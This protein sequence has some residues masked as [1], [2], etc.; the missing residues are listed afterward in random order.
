MIFPAA[1]CLAA[2]VAADA[3]TVQVAIVRQAASATLM[4]DGETLIAQP[5]AK[6]MPLEWKGELALRPRD[7]GLRLANLRLKTETRLL[8]G[9]G[10]RIRVGPN[11]YR[12]ALILRLD[13]GQTV[14]IVEEVEVEEYLEGVL[15]HEMNPDWPLEA[16]KAQAVVARTFTYAN[17]GKFRK[18]G[19]DLTADT[20]SQVYKG[21]T[22]INENV[23]AAVRQTRGEVLG[24]KG[25]L[26]RVYYHACCGGATTDAGAAWGGEGEIPRPLKGVRDPWCAA[27]PHMKW[28]AYFAW[29]DLTA[30]IS[31]RRMLN[32]P[33]QSLRIGARDAAGYVRTFL[34]KS[35][36]ETVELKA[37]ELRGSLGAGEMKSVRIKRL[38]LL[39]K[40]VEFIGGGS[41]H[42]VGLCQWGARLQA[43]KGRGYAKILLFYFPGA[44]LSEVDE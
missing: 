41:G 20:R 34:A 6:P 5:G 31:E 23:R 44:E 4:P 1:L 35:G 17:M 43:E 26:L 11:T 32:S 18:D 10:A 12:G 40:G 38:N 27:S 30:A 39:K 15:P 9:P 13:P 14:T 8:P 22:A 28:I 37:A 24:W 29:A 33:L 19:F 42:G 2:A 16:L 3:A 7:G 25:R 36:G 21:M